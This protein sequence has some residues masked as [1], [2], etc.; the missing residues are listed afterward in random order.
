MFQLLP[1]VQSQLSHLVNSAHISFSQGHFHNF[2]DQLIYG[3][4]LNSLKIIL[5]CISLTHYQQN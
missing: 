4:Q 1:M 5:Q 2:H 3:R